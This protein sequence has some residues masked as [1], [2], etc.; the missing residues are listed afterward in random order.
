MVELPVAIRQAINQAT[1]AD[2]RDR[3]GMFERMRFFAA[4]YADYARAVGLDASDQ[5]ALFGLAIT[6]VPAAKEFDAARLLDALVKADPS[7]AAPRIAFSRLM[8]SM[9]R[10]DTAVAA[11]E[12][13][14]G[15]GTDPD[16]VL[17]Q[18]AALYSD[19][20]NVE[21][22]EPIVEQLRQSRPTAARTYYY[23]ATARFMRGAFADA[24][25]EAR[26]S[27]RADDADA[28]ALN[29]MGAAMASLG[30]REDAKKAFEAALQRAPQDASI[31]VNLGLLALDSG[32]ARRGE[33]LFAGALALDPSSDPALQGL[34]RAAREP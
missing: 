23:A 19:Q 31:Y 16:L 6:A 15:L 30:K 28:D 24:L 2:W 25:V 32:D 29:L 11:A 27:V 4:A 17:E 21:R 13:A 18:L 20:G 9:G 10:T 1:A 3:G 14:K 33:K 22:L 7:A 8:M 26:R 5:Q 12:S 34:Q